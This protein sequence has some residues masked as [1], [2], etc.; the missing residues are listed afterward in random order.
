[1][2]IRITKHQ[3]YVDDVAGET[4]YKIEFGEATPDNDWDKEIATL[5]EPEARELLEELTRVLTNSK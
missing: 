3:E 1:M 4:R 2:T 5:S